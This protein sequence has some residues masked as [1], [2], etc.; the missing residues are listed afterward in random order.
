M[1]IGEV[2][3]LAAKWWVTGPDFKKMLNKLHQLGLILYFDEEGMRD[4]VVIS[5]QYLLE[6]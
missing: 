6:K 3:K 4:F 1:T 2:E 5:P